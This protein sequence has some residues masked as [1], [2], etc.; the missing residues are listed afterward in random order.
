MISI[1]YIHMVFLGMTKKLEALSKKKIVDSMGRQTKHVWTV[2]SHTQLILS[3]Q[4]LQF[5]VQ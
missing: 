2:L 4:F 1:H 5:P 3:S